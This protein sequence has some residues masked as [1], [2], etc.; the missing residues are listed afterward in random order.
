MTADSLSGPTA[1]Q[2]ARRA[3]R[4]SLRASAIFTWIDERGHRRAARG[5]TRDISIK[6]AYI[7]ADLCPPRGTSVTISVFLPAQPDERT[8]I[9]VKAEGRVLR[10]DPAG[11]TS[12]V[13][14][15]SIHNER[16]LICEK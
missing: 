10:V 13:A 9:R 3:V 6:G 1:T 12:Q 4:Y 16:V 15:F 7:A 5:Y 11:R 8:C 14:G 2:E